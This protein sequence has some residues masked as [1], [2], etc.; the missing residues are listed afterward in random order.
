MNSDRWTE[1][2]AKLKKNLKYK[3][4]NLPMRILG[5]SHLAQLSDP[6]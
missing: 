3:K 1:L 2:A 6:S 4:S 5:H